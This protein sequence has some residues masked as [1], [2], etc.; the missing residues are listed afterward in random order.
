M[1]YVTQQDDAADLLSITFESESCQVKK[2][3]FEMLAAMTVYNSRDPSQ[4]RRRVLETLENA[5]EDQ[6][7]MTFL[8]KEFAHAGGDGSGLAFAI[9]TVKLINCLLLSAEVA[10]KRQFFNELGAVAFS[11]EVDKS[12][13]VDNDELLT[14]IDLFD[15]MTNEMEEVF[16]NEIDP[17]LEKIQ[18]LLATTTT[19]KKN[20]ILALLGKLARIDGKN[21][22]NLSK[23]IEE[24]EFEQLVASPQ[25][26]VPAKRATIVIDGVEPPPQATAGPTGPPPPPSG[27]GAPPPPPGPPLPPGGP[28]MPPGPGGAPMPPPPG[29]MH[30]KPVSQLPF[31]PK[32]SPTMKLTPVHW[33][34]IKRNVPV[35]K[36]I[37]SQLEPDSEEILQDLYATLEK[38]FTSKQTLPAK[39]SSLAP[40]PSF[41]A[42]TS[43]LD[44]KKSLNIGIFL[45]QF[46]IPAKEIIS[47]L[48]ESNVRVWTFER[49]KSALKHFD[50]VSSD[51]ELVKNFVGENGDSELGTVEK[52]YHVMSQFFPDANV[53]ILRLELMLHLYRF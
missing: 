52:F 17:E 27:P 25:I 2:A 4:G 14:Q 22:E 47:A 35:E 3:L 44:Q 32:R 20:V 24:N 48:I 5:S 33:E 39:N 43:L 6:T 10:E 7:P 45:K 30:Q 13:G 51:I 26:P 12:R 41:R 49:A 42:K 15:R 1:E 23:Q 37:W 50:D 9:S 34:P 11:S 8:G 31:A 40:K 38:K 18:A 28:P 46:K 53:F 16:S 21:L 29:G 36:S 19:E